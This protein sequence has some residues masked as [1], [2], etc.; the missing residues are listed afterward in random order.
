MIGIVL[1]LK[2]NGWRPMSNGFDENIGKAKLEYVWRC[3]R[4]NDKMEWMKLITKIWVHL[5]QTCKGKNHYRP[6]S[7]LY[8]KNSGSSLDCIVPSHRHWRTG[9]DVEPARTCTKAGEGAQV[10]KGELELHKYIYIYIHWPP[11]TGKAS[12]RPLYTTQGSGLSCWAGGIA[13]IQTQ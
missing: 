4:W 10:C 12:F 2:R 9:V 3:Q 5:T 1:E 7:G 13:E 6:N 11:V 8:T